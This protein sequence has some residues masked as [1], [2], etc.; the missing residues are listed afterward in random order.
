MA[1][2]YRWAMDW[3]ER[4]ILAGCILAIACMTTLIFVGVVMRYGF[5]LG[6]QFAEP[7]SIY[8]AIQLTFYGAAACYRAGVHLKLEFIVSAMPERVRWLA[9]HAVHAIMAAI[10]IFMVVYGISLVET[11]WL[12]S[13]PEFEYIR[14]GW[15][16]TAIPGGGAALL[17]F[18]AE[19]VF[20]PP[21]GRD[22]L[23]EEHVA[24]Q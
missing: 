21:P 19:S 12:Q 14:V 1:D 8:F 5:S 18:V 17:L 11:T 22:H 24:S 3:L 23:A 2:A 9:L 16:Y 10:A 4:I 20:L 6:A 13:Y 15:V 7:V